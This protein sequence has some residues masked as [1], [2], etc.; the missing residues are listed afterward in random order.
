V[1]LPLLRPELPSLEQVAA[2][3]RLSEADHRFSNFG[4]CHELLASRLGDYVG[5]RARCVPVANCTLGLMVSLRALVDGASRGRPFVV[6]PSYTFLATIHAVAWCGFT[7]LFADVDAESWHLSAAALDRA[8]HEHGGE[9]AAVLACSTFGSAPALAERDA[10]EELCRHADV[11]LVVD[12]AAGFG[13]RDEDGQPLGLQGDV[14]AFSFH[15][16]KTMAIGEGGVVITDREDVERTLRR[17]INFGLERP[18]RVA[19]EL[20]LNAK[21]SEIQAAIGLAALDGIEKVLA[22]RRAA[23][24]AVRSAAEGLGVVFQRGSEQSSWPAI[25]V[26]APS[27]AVRDRVL[28]VGAE[29]GVE[30]RTYFD[31]P[32]HRSPLFADSPRVGELAVTEDLAAR[33]LTMPI[34]SGLTSAEIDAMIACV[35][36]AL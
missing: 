23:A 17:L 12:S 9:V 8:L 33:A 28:E 27:N 6:V 22:G 4:P 29:Q 30:F 5:P 16:T 13:S 20:G 11:P 34:A 31:V 24:D 15:A 18:S 36:A 3:Y 14:E 7:P 19:S 2:Y 35:R 25:N 1:G 10:W 21:M 32:M 26:L